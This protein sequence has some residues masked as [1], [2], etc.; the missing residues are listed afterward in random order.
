[1]L[2]AAALLVIIALSAILVAGWCG[3]LDRPPR[4]SRAGTEED[5]RVEWMVAKQKAYGRWLRKRGR[6]LLSDH[7]YEPE[8]HAGNVI[9]LRRKA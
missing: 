1:M 5:P 9:P 3:R 2:M 7:P 8:M 4:P 6:T